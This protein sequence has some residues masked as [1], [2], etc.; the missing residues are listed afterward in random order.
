MRKPPSLSFLEDFIRQKHQIL[1]NFKLAVSKNNSKE[2][3]K[4]LEKNPDLKQEVTGGP[5][6]YNASENGY[7][8]I[9]KI[10][11]NAGVDVNLPVENGLTPL[12]ISSH[13]GH[14]KVVEALIEAGADPNSASTDGKTPLHFASLKG[15]VEVVEAL[16]TTKADPNSAKTDGKTPLHIASLKGHVEVVEALIEAGAKVDSK[17]SDDGITPLHIASQEGH[18]E[19]VEALIKA[20]AK[21]DSKISDGKTPL[22]LASLRGH[23]KV[24]EALIEA[25]AEI[26]SKISDGKTSLHIASQE[27]HVEVVE[28]L[29]EANAEIDSKTKYGS[30]P[31]CLASKNGH[32]QIVKNLLE[33]KECFSDLF[34]PVTL[35]F[36]NNKFDVLEELFKKIPIEDVIILGKE[37]LETTSPDSEKTYEYFKILFESLK[38]ED[39]K[40][41]LITQIQTDK[42]LI[43]TILDYAIENK[44]YKVASLISTK[45]LKNVCENND[46]LEEVRYTILLS[47]LQNYSDEIEFSEFLKSLL[48]SDKIRPDQKEKIEQNKLQLLPEQQEKIDKALD[49]IDK[50]PP[51]IVSKV[52]QLFK[53][54]KYKEFGT[55]ILEEGLGVC[56]SLKYEDNN[57]SNKTL[58]QRLAED[59]S[60]K[61][62]MF[63]NR[64]VNL[65]RLAKNKDK[66]LVFDFDFSADIKHKSTTQEDVPAQAEKLINITTGATALYGA[67]SKQNLNAV[68]LLSEYC[69]IN[70]VTTSYDK[71]GTIL[72]YSLLD[73]AIS[74]ANSDKPINEE[75]PTTKI[76]DHENSIAILKVLTG[77]DDG[78][79]KKAS[80]FR[81]KEH[82][83]KI[84]KK[85]E[86]FKDDVKKLLYERYPN[87]IKL[88]KDE[89]EKADK[90]QKVE[91]SSPAKVGKAGGED[92]VERSGFK[93][94][95]GTFVSLRSMSLVSER[96]SSNLVLS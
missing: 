6:L 20:G 85:F 51:K 71:N 24:V 62:I 67:V 93:L 94:R 12:H 1:E 23:A 3:K 82:R 81:S 25:K 56:L 31:L 91:E 7:L 11:I 28:A 70:H 17:I 86:Y 53:D 78:K 61:S 88:M 74:R 79:G 69:D 41:L 65:F 57:T 14:V 52:W 2:V 4:L 73:V 32:L 76:I 19:V 59:N 54:N 60:D 48:G 21:V 18:V 44:N 27:G 49:E 68:K 80:L 15:H 39:E 13:K 22:H 36:I 40:K 42:N 96:G 87:E 10:L 63:L 50:S 30:T 26:D 35:A 92:R 58:F 8:E 72:E 34:N 16:I 5:A 38:T 89:K 77:G 47:S 64:I 95:D 45:I 43:Y 66:N 90:E 29:I 33:K 83:K 9:V 75:N 37:I 46:E 84:A 55:L